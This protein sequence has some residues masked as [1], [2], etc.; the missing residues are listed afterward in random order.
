MQRGTDGNTQ[1]DNLCNQRCVGDPVSIELKLHRGENDIELKR[2]LTRQEYKSYANI[3][4]LIPVTLKA[5][6]KR[7]ATGGGIDA[8]NVTGTHTRP[9]DPAIFFKPGTQA[10]PI[11]LT[12]L[13]NSSSANFPTSTQADF[14]LTLQKP[15]A[16]ASCSDHKTGESSGVLQ[17]DKRKYHRK[18]NQ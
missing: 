12:T 14:P 15:V 5:G 1:C 17:A 3:R 10:R 7:G 16:T 4:D 8:A 13:C 18:V 6:M 9:I 11:D 2:R